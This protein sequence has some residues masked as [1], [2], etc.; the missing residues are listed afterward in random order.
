[1][2]RDR[3]GGPYLLVLAGTAAGI[4]GLVLGL[5][6]AACGVIVGVAILFGA[7]LRWL[8]PDAKAGALAGRTKGTDVLVLG[9]LGGALV[10][11]GLL[12]LVHRTLL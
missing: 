1:M 4:A 2:N 5:P 12:F 7:L 8:R 10:V 3:V 9:L 11:S 6:A